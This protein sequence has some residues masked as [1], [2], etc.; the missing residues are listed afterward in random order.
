MDVWMD[1]RWM[2]GWIDSWMDG[3]V[4]IIKYDNNIINFSYTEY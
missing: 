4:K 3:S 1:D 2:N